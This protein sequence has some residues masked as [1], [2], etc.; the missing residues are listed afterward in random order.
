MLESKFD[1]ESVIQPLLSSRE[2]GKQVSRIVGICLV[3][4]YDMIDYANVAFCKHIE[5]HKCYLHFH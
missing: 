4:W 5:S 1:V 3:E 2:S